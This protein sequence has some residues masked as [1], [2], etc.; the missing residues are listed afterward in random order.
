MNMLYSKVMN[1]FSNAELLTEII[2]GIINQ[3][4]EK[5]ELTVE[6]KEFQMAHEIYGNDVGLISFFS[7]I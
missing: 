3:L 6:E 5:D 7:L 4:S 2:D 1:S